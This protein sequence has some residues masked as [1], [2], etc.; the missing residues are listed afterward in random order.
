M[1]SPHFTAVLSKLYVACPLSSLS[2][3]D[4][5]VAVGLWYPVEH[6]HCVSPNLCCL[7]FGKLVTVTGVL[8]GLVCLFIWISGLQNLRTKAFIWCCSGRPGSVTV[9]KPIECSSKSVLTRCGDV[10]Q[11]QC[12]YQHTRTS[13]PT[14]RSEGQGKPWKIHETLQLRVNFL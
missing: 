9:A 3:R 6:M 8:C 10:F 1:C 7:C 4:G 5:S 14:A 2:H 13:H 11:S 12:P